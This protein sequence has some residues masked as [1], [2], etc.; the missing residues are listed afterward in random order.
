M[1]DGAR[2]TVIAGV[3]GAGKSSVAGAALRQLGGE[4]FN[5]DE[6][7]RRFLTVSPS[8][9]AEEANS[10][11]WAE[12]RRRLEEAIRSRQ[13]YAFETTLG[14]STMTRLLFEALGEELD[15][16]VLFVGLGNAELH[17]ARI[18]S[19]VAAGGHAIAE[20]KVRER[21]IS[22]IKNL[23]SLAPYLSELR[24]FDN[25]KDAD[26]KTGHRPEPRELLYASAGNLVRS[27]ELAD[28]PDWAKP[29]LMV[30]LQPRA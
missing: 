7:T 13:D 5:P 12:G 22:S 25:S 9:S 15:V 26:P 14:G 8:M 28:C 19:R 6:A 29:V 21:Y 16:G 23:V 20:S 18:A 4:Y 1:V 10:R 11:A 2:I 24:V 17:L 27:L 3:N 30:L